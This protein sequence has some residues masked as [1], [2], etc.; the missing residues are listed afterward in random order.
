MKYARHEYERRFLLASPD[1]PDSAIRTIEINDLYFKGTRIRLRRAETVEGEGAGVAE[2]KLTQKVPDPSGGPGLITTFYLTLAEYQACSQ[3]PGSMLRKTRMSVPP[4]AV[5][6]FR[7]PLAGLYLAEAEFSSLSELSAYV[8]PDWVAAELT[9]DARFRGG[10]LVE[11]DAPTL[12]QWLA[13]YGL[14]P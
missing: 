1:V 7:G 3:M 9:A 8:P 12:R 6:C 14:D 2:Y 5:D 13:E 11:T 4:L 10:T